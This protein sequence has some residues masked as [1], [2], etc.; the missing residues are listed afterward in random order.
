MATIFWDPQ[1]IIMIDYLEKGK[2]IIGEYYT[3]L[4]GRLVTEKTTMHSPINQKYEKKID[5][6]T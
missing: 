3:K 1:G 6:L 5:H 4:F 2:T